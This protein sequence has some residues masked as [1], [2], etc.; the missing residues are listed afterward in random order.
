[1]KQEIPSADGSGEQIQRERQERFVDRIIDRLK[2]LKA[3]GHSKRHVFEHW[4][5]LIA[6]PNVTDPVGR[7]I[8]ELG[9][10]ERERLTDA[11]EE[12]EAHDA[13]DQAWLTAKHT[14]QEL[15]KLMEDPEVLPV[16]DLVRKA[17]SGKPPAPY[18]DF[19][20]TTFVFCDGVRRTADGNKIYVHEVWTE[21]YVQALADHYGPMIAECAQKTPDEP[22]VLLEVGAGDGK[23]G[24]FL[25]KELQ[26]RYGERVS[27]TVTDKRSGVNSP[28]P[29]IQQG[30]QE[31]LD[32]QL[33]Q[34]GKVDAVM[35]SWMPPRQDWT[36][37]FRD[38]KYRIQEYLLIGEDEPGVSGTLETWDEYPGFSQQTLKA[39]TREQISHTDPSPV[40]GD[41]YTGDGYF[42]SKTVAFQKE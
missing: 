37:T 40:E 42:H 22:F 6:Y 15:F 23:L 36:K 9:A 14:P 16:R 33:A 7:A 21:E 27:I 32:A 24:Y 38:P 35:V 34:Y 5:G 20:N 26:K 13:Y 1:M 12:V 10:E 30:Y 2:T 19:P 4:K 18:A 29:V 28:F 17:F 11:W 41:R 3:I 31:A 39:P 25:R 8:S